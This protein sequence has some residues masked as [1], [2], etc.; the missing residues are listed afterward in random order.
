MAGIAEESKN[1]WINAFKQWANEVWIM[2]GNSNRLTCDD[3]EVHFNVLGS[4]IFL[5]TVSKI[6]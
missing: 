3:I 6:Q 2:E 5:R 1:G 4:N